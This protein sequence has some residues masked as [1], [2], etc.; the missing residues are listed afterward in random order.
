M[1]AD[2]GLIDWVKEAAEPLGTITHKRLFGGAALYADG[3]AFA[4]VAFDSL[5]FK[6]D[7]ES[8]EIWDAEGCGR[9]T[10]EMKGRTASMNYR[11]APD[12]V[13]DDADTLQRWA[14]LA[15]E[16]GRRAPPKKPKRRRG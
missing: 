4:I 15:I 2:T 7:A 5:W 6:A 12:D 1:A 9:F 11:R 16:A 14:M 10:V 13:Y 8:D 3:V